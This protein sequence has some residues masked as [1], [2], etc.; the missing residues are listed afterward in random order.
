M[1]DGP[2]TEADVLSPS[3]RALLAQ[4]LDARPIDP[5]TRLQALLGTRVGRYQIEALLG[6]GGMGA[7]Y[8]AMDGETRAP[9]ALKLLHPTALGGK[10]ERQ[11]LEFRKRFR[12]EARRGLMVAHPGVA[13]VYDAGEIDGHL[14]IA[15]EFIEGYTLR[16]EIRRPTAPEL[17][18]RLSMLRQV[19]DVLAAVHLQNLVHRDIKPDNVMVADGGKI[20]LLD[21]GLARFTKS[22]ARELQGASDW[23]T[24]VATRGGVILGTP[25]YMAPEQVLGQRL[26]PAADIF[27]LGITAFEFLSGERP[28]RGANSMHV[29]LSIARDEPLRLEDTFPEATPAVCELVAGCLHKDPLERPSAEALERQLA[30]V[31]V[32]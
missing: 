29:M 12:G 3:E 13:R 31:A 16:R 6:A 17:P 30:A 1:V 24:Q 7:V 2:D 9:V 4:V 28:F 14:F 5:A 26:T 22:P 20:K 19:A 11:Y 15:M 21:F 27:A 18:R 32:A 8:R 25:H 10:D 23:T